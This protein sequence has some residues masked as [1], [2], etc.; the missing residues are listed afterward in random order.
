[1]VRDKGSGGI[2]YDK[3]K[4][5]WIGTIEAGWTVRGTRR[6]IKVSARTK[7]ECQTKLRAKERELLAA[8][9]PDEG[10]RSGTTV[11]AYADQWLEVQAG[12]LRPGAY[13]ATASQVRTWIVPTI[14]HRRLDRLSPA[15]V[16]SVYQAALKA[17]RAV[18]TANRAHAELGRL[19]RDAHEDGHAVPARVLK[20]EGPGAGRSDRDAIPL[21]DAMDILAAASE[22]PDAARWLLAFMEAMRPAEVLGLTWRR[23]DFDAHTITVDWQLKRLPYSVAR[24]RSSGFRVPTNY[25]ARQLVGAAHLVRPKTSSGR[26]T[27]PMVPWVESALLTWRDV[28]PK[29][30]H[31]LVF[32]RD[33][34]TPRDDAVDRAEFVALQDAAHVASVDEDDRGRRYDLYEARHTTATLL[35][36]SGVDD[37]TIIAIMGHASILS[38]KAY[39]HSDQARMREA[40]AAVEAKFRPRIGS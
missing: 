24:D 29:S 20:V 13:G 30:R 32:P 15:D 1:M 9:T 3:A 2:T 31:G 27:I 19:L 28:A 10:S 25:E 33:A 11:K 37:E 16:R 36:Q 6:R 5:R 35:R 38:T 18:S 39:L 22:K 12:R 23:V 4:D 8:G 26:R 40:L 34:D 7:R 21:D 17:G 14:G